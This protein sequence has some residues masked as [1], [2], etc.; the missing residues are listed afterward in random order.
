MGVHG[1]S[2]C[3][4]D[5]LSLI[6]QSSLIC[7]LSHALD[8][9]PRGKG[10]PALCPFMPWY[11]CSCCSF[12]LKF[13]PL[14]CQV[15][16]SFRT[17]LSHPSENLNSQLFQAEVVTS[18]CPLSTVPLLPVALVQLSKM[19]LSSSHVPCT[20]LCAQCQVDREMNRTGF[21]PLR[22]SQSGRKN[23]CK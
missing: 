12:Y 21:L 14:L 19:F 15:N 18:V 17:E 8:S 5:P 3:G 4:P 13:W 10:V 23:T 16:F 9:Q 7:F 2:Q 6:F 11:L 20:V 1:F 22:N